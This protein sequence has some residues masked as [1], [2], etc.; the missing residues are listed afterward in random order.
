MAREARRISEIHHIGMGDDPR[1]I[2]I[3]VRVMAAIT[4]GSRGVRDRCVVAHSATIGFVFED[5]NGVI[6]SAPPWGMGHLVPMTGGAEFLL[7][8]ASVT[9]VGAIGVHHI[10]MSGKPRILD[11]ALRVVARVAIGARLNLDVE[12]VAHRTAFVTRVEGDLHMVVYEI[13]GV[14]YLQSVA[15][16]AELFL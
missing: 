6:G 4:F 1:F 15:R 9:C 3:A 2:E 7:Y 5:G 16:V 14:G 12:Y 13:L 11:I 10:W 8:V